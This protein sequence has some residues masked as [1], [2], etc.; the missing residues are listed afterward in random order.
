MAHRPEQ[1]NL[2]TIVRPPNSVFRPYASIG[3]KLLF[4]EKGTPTEETSFWEHRIPEV[5]KACSMTR[6]IRLEH[7]D[8]CTALWVGPQR[9][10]RVETGCAGTLSAEEIKA[11]NDYLDVKNPHV[12]EEDHRDHQPLLEELTN[13]GAEIVTS[14]YQLKQILY[15]ALLR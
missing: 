15:E 9:Q 4:S 13:A 3:T 7:L 1:S 10:A 8:D 11:R 5:Q 6:P 12:E 14:R 2:H